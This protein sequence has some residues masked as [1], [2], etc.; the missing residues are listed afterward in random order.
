MTDNTYRYCLIHCPLSSVTVEEKHKTQ[1][2]IFNIIKYFFHDIY[3]LENYKAGL[4]MMDVGLTA[5]DN[6]H[7]LVFCQNTGD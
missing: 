3:N 4:R 2:N 7:G 5:T 1:G 6:L